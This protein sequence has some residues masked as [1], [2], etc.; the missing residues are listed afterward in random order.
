MNLYCLLISIFFVNVLANDYA[1]YV[2]YIYITTET[3]KRASSM[4]DLTV[5]GRS[6]ANGLEHVIETMVDDTTNDLYYKEFCKMNFLMA[7]PDQ[8]DILWRVQAFPLLDPL[9]KAIIFFQ[10]MIQDI[11]RMLGFR[12]NKGLN[13]EMGTLNAIA[14][15]RRVYLV[16]ALNSVIRRRL[17]DGSVPH[18]DDEAT[19]LSN[20]RLLGLYWSTQFSKLYIKEVEIDPTDLTC[21]LTNIIGAKRRY[22]KIGN[23]WS[24]INDNNQSLKSL[25]EQLRFDTQHSS[26]ESKNSTDEEDYSLHNHCSLT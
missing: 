13:Q 16:P 21:I 15:E 17:L 12:W 7:V 25:E 2:E 11:E 10:M 24:E 3:I 20:C 9:Q 8:T 6:G 26:D 22:R 14:D 23:A 18:V 1:L 4:N 5:G 19:I